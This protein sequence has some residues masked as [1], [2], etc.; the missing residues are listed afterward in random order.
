MSDHPVEVEEPERKLA[1]RSSPI[2]QQ[3]QAQPAQIQEAPPP[4]FTPPD[5]QKPLPES[6]KQFRQPIPDGKTPIKTPRGLEPLSTAKQLVVKHDSDMIEAKCKCYK[7]CHYEVYNERHQLI[8]YAAEDINAFSLCCMTKYRPYRMRIY[9]QL[10]FNCVLFR[11]MI[12]FF[13]QQSS[14]EVPVSN[15]MATIKKTSG[16]ES[17]KPYFDVVDS[18]GDLAFKIAPAPGED[19]GKFEIFGP[20]QQTKIGELSNQW[21]GFFREA[22]AAGK[23]SFGISLPPDMDVGWKAVLLGC[24]FFIDYLLFEG[25]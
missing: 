5:F 7:D 18:K 22:F 13:A 15:K 3:P 25:K 14:I 20:D 6:M 11:G 24:L 4:E 1:D 12:T 19:V 16:P 2:E 17:G 10:Q 21:S 23:E 9:D 8:Y